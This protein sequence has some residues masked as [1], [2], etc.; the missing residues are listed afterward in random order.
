MTFSM[1]CSKREPLPLL[2][3]V[4]KLNVKSPLPIKGAFYVSEKTKTAVYRSPDDIPWQ[5][6]PN[7]EKIRPFEIRVGQAF[8]AT[9]FQAF[10]QV[11]DELTMAEGLP[12][13]KS[14]GLILEPQL[15]TI[16]LQ[17]TY[18]NFGNTPN[19]Q[20]LDVGGFLEARLRL[21]GE[22]KKDWEKAYRVSIPTQRILVGPWSGERISEMVADALASLIR[23]MA[24]ELDGANDKPIVPLSQW[25]Q[26]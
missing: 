17:M 16:G 4:G 13:G 10:S 20:M 3:R 23:E 6:M 5:I 8:T 7:T 21:K 11:V 15:D 24:F 14:F 2:P 26:S 18:V 25:L 12:A 1:G 9:A 22:G 19:D